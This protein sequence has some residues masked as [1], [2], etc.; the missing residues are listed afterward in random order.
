MTAA[1]EPGER[2]TDPRGGPERGSERGPEPRPE[3]GSAPMSGQ[4]PELGPE[5]G[6]EQGPELGPERDQLAAL[7]ELSSVLTRRFTAQGID[8]PDAAGRAAA[9]IDACRRAHAALGGRDER[10]AGVAFRWANLLAIRR[11]ALG[12]P[13]GDADAA[14]T[15]FEEFLTA[16]EPSPGD[17]EIA[18][19]WIGLLLMF[20]VMRLPT[21]GLGNPPDQRALMALMAGFKL[22]PD[23][24]ADVT[25]AVACF[26]RLVD[27][28]PAH[29]P[30]QRIATSMHAMA[31][32]FEMINAPA[33][34][35]MDMPR[36]LALVGRASAALAAD[37]PGRP[38]LVALHAWLNADHVRSAGIADADGAVIRELQEASGLIPPEHMLH[39]V[40]QLELGLS[41]A[42]QAQRS[43]SAQDMRNAPR[44]IEAAHKDMEGW[45]GHPLYD[46]SLRQL[47]GVLT[48][49]TAY[50][51]TADGIEKVINL[52][53]RAL[54]G[55]DLADVPGVAKD[56]YLLGMALTLRAERTQR[57][58]DWAEAMS[59]LHRALTL[60]PASD[61]LATTML[62]TFGAALND[63]YQ[64]RGGLEDAEAARLILDRAGD[65]LAVGR[66]ASDRVEDHELLTTVG[67][68]GVCRTALA[69]R[70]HDMAALGR[71]AEEIKQALDGLPEEYP[72]RSRLLSGLGLNKIAHGVA[73]GDVTDI[74]A[75]VAAL[76]EAAAIMAI[77]A[78]SR[79]SIR[80]VGGMA[81]IIDGRLQAD[82]DRLQRGIDMLAEAV[83]V[84]DTPQG[85]RARLL[86]A[87]GFAHLVW[88]ELDGSADQIDL[89]IAR[90]E[91]AR[92]LLAEDAVNPIAG[93]L[94]W[95]LAVAYRQR[96]DA[97]QDDLGRSADTGL[98][99]LRA[100]IYEVL[101]QSGA[102]HGLVT[103]R[104]AAG[105]ATELARW[106]LADGRQDEAVEALE[107]GRGLVLHAATTATRVPEMLRGAA[108]V[109]LA[110]EWENASVGPAR[111]LTIGEP[112]LPE[113]VAAELAAGVL[114]GQPPSD[115]RQRVLAALGDVDEVERLS[116][117]PTAAEIA[118]T[119]RASGAD[120]L[121]YLV[122]GPAGD[123]GH[124]L[125]VLADERVQ[126][127][128]A[129]RLRVTDDG[130][131]VAY[132]V[133]QRALLRAAEDDDSAVA[134]HPDLLE[135]WRAALDSVGR[136]AWHAAI[137]P[138]LGQL[139]R[140]GGSQPPRVILVPGGPLG[141]V[142]WHAAWVGEAEGSRTYACRELVFSYAASARQL[143]DAT[144][145]KRL[146]LMADPV[147]VAD[148]TR[149]L[150][151]ATFQTLALRRCLYPNSRGLGDTGDRGDPVGTPEQVLAHIP[152]RG[153]LGASMLQFSC[154]GL[155]A[156]SPV[157]S[158]LRLV[159]PTGS[160]VEGK[161]DV[162]RI[163]RRA[164]GRR[165]DAPG[166]LVV[167][168]AC[169]SDVTGTDYDE[170]LTL[171]TAFLAAGAVSVVGSRWEVSDRMTPV[172]MFMFHRFLT[173]YDMGP[174][175]AL[176]AT[177]L[178]MLDRNRAAPP[179]MPPLLAGDLGAHDFTDTAVWAA[180]THQGV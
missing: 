85:E 175:D 139:G 94:L 80:A 93:P 99:A 72:W 95:R 103:A 176:R 83:A 74:R 129:E 137:E 29:P 105:E 98:A 151:G 160:A 49:S 166:G 36:I 179:D 10:R 133:A 76:T 40:L 78:G 123:S 114:S 173:V 84:E 89:G 15:L 26:G 41:S 81:H 135:E 161:L 90:L 62:A 104:G 146:P 23:A 21:Q 65:I 82:P 19:F 64:L 115:L 167:L 50:E 157:D 58:E 44:L 172:L 97:D 125:A 25:R 7:V 113:A 140:R 69:W 154:H 61:P 170:A 39:A 88:Y 37:D 119:L 14:I 110:L 111:D 66:H 148:P 32:M 168:A 132:A 70:M 18:N 60:I 6:P 128:P 43:G 68:R 158:Y 92:S 9:A 79:A 16:P 143:I 35:G 27:A 159:D 67:I 174:A 117:A 33:A 163:L 153:I 22:E 102:G 107:L 130:P 28:E 13:D 87:L 77:D 122:P 54:A 71:G 47:A 46:D 34:E 108:H 31:S 141:I 20:R 30:L 165:P 63:R 149:S 56:T 138:L 12:G 164:H 118:S 75:G 112:Q 59:H 100:H 145:R 86:W 144:R 127:I 180:F 177:Q 155:S 45:P 51:P 171:S 142:P 91:Q 5:Q 8:A 4:G 42:H 2:L 150:P 134:T 1:R 124:L 101:L 3:Q 120:A 96:A 11:V 126:V 24:A 52:A 121:V 152:G 131:V 53:R 57:P 156:A 147:F 73:V 169:V 136:W 109:A 17:A 55:R 162:Q 116:R 106:C 48:S 38:E 178:W